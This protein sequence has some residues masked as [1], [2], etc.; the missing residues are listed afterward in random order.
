MIG[1]AGC[2]TTGVDV[3]W[4]GFRVSSSDL[5]RDSGVQIGKSDGGGPR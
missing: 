4:I 5:V 2:T 3:D 1:V